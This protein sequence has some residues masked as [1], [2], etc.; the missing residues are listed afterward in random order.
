MKSIILVIASV[1][2]LGLLSTNAQAVK[3]WNS[4]KSNTS[5]V[6]APFD[7][8]VI[9]NIQAR[10]DRVRPNQLTEAK[11]REILK[12]F[13]ITR[14]MSIVIEPKGN[15]VDVYI[16]KTLADLPAARKAL[17]GPKSLRKDYNEP[18]GSEP[19]K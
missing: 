15:K 8:G 12:E 9:K 3:N 10:I 19:L 14:P 2:I 6:V 5:T 1:F 18:K 13:R 11:V 17:T 7:S 4:S 16:L